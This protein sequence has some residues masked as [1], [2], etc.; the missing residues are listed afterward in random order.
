MLIILLN[1][2][3]NFWEM[4]RDVAFIHVQ[5]ELHEN[6]IQGEFVLMYDVSDQKSFVDMQE[7]YNDAE[8]HSVL[9]KFS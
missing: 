1:I 2:R 3:A 6:I 5:N 8:G 4:S 7:L 9:E